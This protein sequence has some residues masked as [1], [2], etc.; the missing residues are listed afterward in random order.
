MAGLHFTVTDDHLTATGDKTTEV[1]SIRLLG[2]DN[3]TNLTITNLYRLPMGTTDDEREDRFGL[4]VLPIN[5]KILHVGDVKAHN[6]MW[7]A[8]C[9]TPDEVGEM[10]AGH[11][12]GAE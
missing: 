9:E 3:T 5:N 12:E 10:I 11:L 1:S 2:S 4:L 6:P 8:A 7:D